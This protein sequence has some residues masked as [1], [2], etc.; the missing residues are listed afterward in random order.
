MSEHV[1]YQFLLKNNMF[2]GCT[3][4]KSVKFMIFDDFL[5]I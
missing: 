1:V 2:K 4:K 3:S 5:K